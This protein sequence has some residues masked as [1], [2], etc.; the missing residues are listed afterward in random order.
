MIE[1][2]IEKGI[3]MNVDFMKVMQLDNVDIQARTSL[4]DMIACVE[5]GLNTPNSNLNQTH[6]KLA[7]FGLSHLKKWDANFNLESTA[8]S[9]FDAWEF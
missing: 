1:D 8:A 5:R 7:Q 6:V 9:I 2:K 3:K 4:P